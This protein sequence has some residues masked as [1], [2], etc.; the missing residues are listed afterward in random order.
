MAFGE[1]GGTDQTFQFHRFAVPLTDPIRQRRD[2]CVRDVCHFDRI[3][4]GRFHEGRVTGL[5]DDVIGARSNGGPGQIIGETFGGGD[6]QKRDQTSGFEDS[7]AGS[8]HGELVRQS[9]ENI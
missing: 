8:Q 9:T 5:G 1:L 4:T 2:V 6:H 3:E 7:V